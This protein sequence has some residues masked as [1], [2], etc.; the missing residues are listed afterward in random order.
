MVGEKA[1]GLGL[2]EDGGELAQRLAH[3]AGLHAHGGHAHLAFEFGLGHQRGHRIDDDDVDGSRTGQRLA[4]GQSL[5]AGVGLG[6][7]KFIDI[8]SKFLGVGRVQ[9]VLSIDESSDTTGLLG[10]GDQVQHQSGFSGGFW[11]VDLHHTATGH[12]AHTQR[13]IDSECPGGDDL[14]GSGDLRSEAHDRPLAVSLGDGGNGGIEF[15]LFGCGDLGHLSNG[16]GFGLGE[17]SLGEFC[18]GGW[19]LLFGGFFGHRGVG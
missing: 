8:H 16:G 10:V 14:D 6:D 17:F 13:K 2:A 3:E 11:T 19:G 4:D 15:P 12:A 9:S 7:Q 18:L 5:F 1:G